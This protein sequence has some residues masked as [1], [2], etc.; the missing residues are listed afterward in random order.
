MKAISVLFA[1]IVFILAATLSSSFS[2]AATQSLS[3][4][5]IPLTIDQSQEFGVGI[6]FSCPGCTSDSYLR[7]VFYPNG[8]SY[9]GYTQDNNNNW[10]NA[11]AGSCTTYFKIT[12]TDLSKDGTWS[13]TLK[14]KPD[15]DNSYYNGPG[16]YLFKVGR[17]TPSCGSPLW[18]TE[19]TI[20]I[21]GPTPTPTPADTSTPT[22]T[23][24]PTPTSTPIVTPTKTPTPTTRI[25]ISPTPTNSQSRV[26]VLGDETKISPTQ[27][28]NQSTQVASI[29][30]N[31]VMGKIFIVLGIIFLFLCG[32]VVFWSYKDKIFN[33]NEL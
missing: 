18:S 11:A 24:K 23:S 22:P 6:T 25:S 27:V 5:N 28:V 16:E 17:Y 20:A 14:L 31:N 33:K 21:T 15:K 8:T 9:F 1:F 7:G 19:T 3:V 4:T 29:S 32:I 13:G 26:S 2:F 12:Q 30:S 10:N